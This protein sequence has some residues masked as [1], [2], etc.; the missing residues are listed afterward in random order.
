MTETSE[1]ALLPPGLGDVLAP[2]ARIE[3]ETVTRLMAVFESYGYER[4]K[5]PLIEFEENLLAGKGA[6]I[7]NQTFR[8]MDPVSQRMLALRPDMTLQIARIAET[9]LG[10]APRPLRLAYAG[11]VVRIKGSQLRPERQFGQVGVELIGTDVTDADAETIL[12][13]LEA[14][15]GL[16]IKNLS[17]DLGMPSLVQAIMGTALTKE[18]EN[19]LRQALDRKDTAAIKAMSDVLGAGPT[20]TLLALLGAMGPAKPGLEK[21]RALN[22]DGDGGAALLALCDVV[23]A[24]LAARPSLVLT[25]DPVENRGFE[26]HTGVSFT[27]FAKNVRG[28]LGRG[29]RYVVG[30]G[31]EN[32]AGNSAGETA[33]GFT[34]FMDTVLR[35]LPETQP[36]NRLFLEA[37]TNTDIA[38]K[39]RA[40]GWIVIL[41]MDPS[42]EAETEARRLRCSHLLEGGKPRQL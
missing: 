32:G 39:Y 19:T 5:P 23:D 36:A 33:T 29:G 3:A 42:Q 9:R 20:K 28:E 30:N 22:L 7:A 12:M 10:N 11:E 18:D 2:E 26:Y 6:T 21:M 16:G 14:M 38:K 15:E 37:G 34:L 4:V 27:F 24:L 8:L 40:E 17:V 25:V 31:A 13:A 41:G 1:K 35:S